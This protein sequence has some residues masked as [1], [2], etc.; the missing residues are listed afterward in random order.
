MADVRLEGRWDQIK[1]RVKE[2]WGVIT[3]DDL[4]KTAGRWDQVVGV[5]MVKTGESM[6]A[7]EDRLARMLDETEDR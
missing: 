6:D 7:I 3:D 1:G 4:T 5:I 2:A